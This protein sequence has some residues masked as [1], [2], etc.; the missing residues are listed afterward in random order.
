MS[1]APGTLGLT[2][3]APATQMGIIEHRIKQELARQKRV[4]PRGWADAY[5]SRE[6]LFLTELAMSLNLRVEF[7]NNQA[8]FYP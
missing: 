3:Y 2:I 1:Y 4:N 8:R 6:E 5:E 7:G